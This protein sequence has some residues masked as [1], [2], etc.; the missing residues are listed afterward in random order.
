MDTQTLPGR[1][2]QQLE[3]FEQA[4]ATNAVVGQ[5][6]DVL[7]HSL[8]VE[9]AG[10]AFADQRDRGP[11]AKAVE[12]LQKMLLA[13][14][15]GRVFQFRPPEAEKSLDF[16]CFGWTEPD[17]QWLTT[18]ATFDHRR[19]PKQRIVWV[20]D[21]D[22]VAGMLREMAR[23]GCSSELQNA[24]SR[25]GPDDEAPGSKYIWFWNAS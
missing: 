20:K 18:H 16:V 25:F 19:D 15:S 14:R 2:D 23:A 12:D 6:I 7:L 1:P 3:Q 24:I 11:V 5:M 10:L 17:A 13:Y 9:S 21:T 22:M 8:S 4:E